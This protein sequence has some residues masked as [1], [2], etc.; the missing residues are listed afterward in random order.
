M[1]RPLQKISDITTA[2][3]E[4]SAKGSSNSED[5]RVRSVFYY[6]PTNPKKKWEPWDASLIDH[7]G[8]SINAIIW[9][10]SYPISDIER[11][12][13]MWYTKSGIAYIEGFG[14]TFR[15]DPQIQIKKLTFIGPDAPDYYEL[16]EL[17]TGHLQVLYKEKKNKKVVELERIIENEVNDPYYKKLL[18]LMF[19]D[20][21]KSR[22]K[23]AT[24][25]SSM[26]HDYPGGL[27]VHTLSVAKKCKALASVS[28][29]SIN[30]DLLITAALLH[31]IA[32]VKE[33]K[34][35]P[36]KERTY[37][38]RILGHP[39]MGAEMIA[40]KIQEIRNGIGVS[41]ERFTDFPEGHEVQLKHCI[42]SHH[43]MLEYGAA[44]KPMLLEAFY[45]HFADNMDAKEEF[46]RKN[47]WGKWNAKEPL[48]SIGGFYNSLDDVYCYPTFDPIEDYKPQPNPL[49]LEMSAN[50][51]DI[52]FSQ[53]SIQ[54]VPPDT[55]YPDPFW[56]SNET[57]DDIFPD[58]SPF[59]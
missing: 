27:L 54:D 38:G 20:D 49:T 23:E 1:N 47:V 52:P 37:I 5:T 2:I 7:E 28:D 6:T 31:D 14:K 41:D 26:H 46:Y 8:K 39:Y 51:Y 15:G 45:L 59:V 30:C 12:D 11:A 50:N 34:S 33:Y 18:Q 22:F 53:P 44:V 58:S 43:G 55:Y 13:P 36:S 21:M 3:S 35:F 9:I 56:D 17:F 29:K 24:A 16:C 40:L 19:D 4:N 32:K 57:S 48:E 10:S 25:A 42:L